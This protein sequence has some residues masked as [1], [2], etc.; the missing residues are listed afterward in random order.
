[1]CPTSIST[2]LP[3]GWSWKSEWIAR[4]PRRRSRRRSASREKKTHACSMRSDKR[5]AGGKQTH[6]KEPSNEGATSE[7]DKDR[8]Y[9]RAGIGIPTG[10]GA[11]AYGWHECG[12]AQLLPRGF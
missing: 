5:E 7:Q 10:D 12:A 8:L 3:T 4:R 2:T 11:D 6:L 1:M 9:Y